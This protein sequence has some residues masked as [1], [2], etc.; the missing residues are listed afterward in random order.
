MTRKV[1]LNHT[2]LNFI[3]PEKSYMYVKIKGILL[4]P[5]VWR[6]QGIGTRFTF[7]AWRST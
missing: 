5:A 4:F 1:L 3:F 2:I 6:P 7:E